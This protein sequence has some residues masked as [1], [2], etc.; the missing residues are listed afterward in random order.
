MAELQNDVF[1]K[2]AKVRATILDDVEGKKGG[3][4][5][6]VEGVFQG[7]QVLGGKTFFHID[8][9]KQAGK[10]TTVEKFSVNSDYVLY[11]EPIAEPEEAPKGKGS[12]ASE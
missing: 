9:E 6:T 1:N 12:K 8:R 7:T 2:G 10:N 11:L 3:G 5:L 4:Q